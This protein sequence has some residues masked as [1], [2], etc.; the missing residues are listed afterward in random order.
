MTDEHLTGDGEQVLTLQT[1]I[2]ARMDERGWTYTDLDR[3]SD[4]NL[5]KGRWQQLGSGV[6]QRSFPE[7][8]TV[9][10]IADVLEVEVT[11]VV[12][13]AAQSVGLDARRRGPDLAHLLP[14]GTDRLSERMRDAILT[15]IR[16]AVAETLT[17][18][19][20]DEDATEPGGAVT[21]EWRKGHTQQSRSDSA[22]RTVDNQT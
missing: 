7:P 16:A 5:T 20:D 9:A 17:Q 21:L 6:R 8:T 22:R 3:R 12:L 1:L 11:T 10:L 13:A 15:I 14:A 18:A 19:V 4:G 2:R